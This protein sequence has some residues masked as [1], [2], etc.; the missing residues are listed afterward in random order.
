MKDT[1]SRVATISLGLAMAAP[2]AGAQSLDHLTLHGYLTQGYAYSTDLPVLGI[3]TEA[4]G[5]YRTAALQF[6]YAVTG[7]DNLVLQIRHAEIGNSPYIAGND[8]VSLD[9]VFYQRRIS[10]GSLRIGRVPMPLGMLAETRDVGTLMPFYRAPA[11]VYFEGFRTVDGAMLSH[12]FDLPARFNVDVSAFG[13]G[14]N[15]KTVLRGPYGVSAVDSRFE[16]ARGGN[17]VVG[18]PISGLRVGGSA[19]RMRE[20]DTLTS[21][22]ATQVDV[23]YASVEYAKERFFVRSELA[24]VGFNTT[25]I[26]NRYVHAGVKLTERI[27]VNGQVDFSDYNIGTAAGPFTFENTADRAA[28]A[29]YAL[30]SSV[31]FKIEHHRVKGYDFDTFVMPGGTPGKTS[32]T[33]GSV[34]VAF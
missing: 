31:V 9:W 16:E 17:I 19:M 27:G 1:L 11:S 28:S 2:N 14:F 23:R 18:T 10:T 33:I 6:R 30:T 8:A 4:T 29:N 15:G 25:H 22:P 26:L 21:K 7:A 32:Y 12:A 13:G 34:S 24:H 20:M 5:N 3:P